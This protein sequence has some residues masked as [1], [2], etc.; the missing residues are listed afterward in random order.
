MIRKIV[1]EVHLVLLFFAFFIITQ[2]EKILSMLSPLN[3]S[4]ILLLLF[5]GGM[6]RR[7]VEHYA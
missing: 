1:G 7:D 4:S 3:I 2:Y 6:V 5:I